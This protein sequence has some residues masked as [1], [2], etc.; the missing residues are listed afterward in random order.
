MKE[1]KPHLDSLAGNSVQ[2][3]TLL[4]ENATVLL[5]QILALHAVLQDTR[6][7]PH[8]NK[9]LECQPPELIEQTKRE[10]KTR[11]ERARLVANTQ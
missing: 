8:H 11:R 4:L 9:G 5:E 1:H 3:R 2:E 7:R 10:L 6:L